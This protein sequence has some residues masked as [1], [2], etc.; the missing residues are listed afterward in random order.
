MP[1][2]TGVQEVLTC[3]YTDNTSTDCT[4]VVD[5]HGNVGSGFTSTN[6]AVATV[7]SIGLVTPVG[8]GVTTLSATAGGKTSTLAVTVVTAVILGNNQENT[9]GG[10]FPNTFNSVYAVTGNNA[11]GY[12]VQGC[13]FFL[14]TGTYT[15]GKHWDCG[16]TLATSP[17]TQATTA[18]CWST[19]TNPTSGSDSF[20]T[21]IPTCPIIGPNQGYWVWTVTDDPASPSSFGF[22]NCGS[23]C[24][25]PVPT[26]NVGTYAGFFVHNNYGTY[27]GMTPTLTQGGGGAGGNQPSQFATLSP[28][29]K[30]IVVKSTGRKGN[31]MR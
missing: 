10:T 4:N 24:T 30:V 16:V 28:V 15:I 25:G 6:T 5:G 9:N 26:V 8:P 18:L 29:Q 20:V 17:T 19:F 1:L 7:N 22:W 13:S 21:V 12:I 23:I 14:P 31:W 11:L 3:R 2:G 27:T